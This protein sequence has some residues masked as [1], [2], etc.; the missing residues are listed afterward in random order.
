[1]KCTKLN[2]EYNPGNH[3]IGDFGVI[4]RGDGIDVARLIYS[5]MVQEEDIATIFITAIMAYM[6]DK[7]LT[8]EE[9]TDRV[10]DILQK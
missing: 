4:M 10:K 3:R 6:H 5:A 1:M 8:C 9:F 2:L 7:G